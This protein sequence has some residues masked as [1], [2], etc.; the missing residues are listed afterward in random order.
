MKTKTKELLIGASVGL[1]IVLLSWNI[2]TLFASGENSVFNQECQAVYGENYSY[3][4]W[5]DAPF[6]CEEKVYVFA[7]EEGVYQTEDVYIECKWY[8]VEEN[9]G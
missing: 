4:S 3:V 5:M 9:D 8:P 7:N 6:C 1:I 2:L